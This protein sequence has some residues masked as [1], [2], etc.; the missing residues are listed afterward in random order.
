MLP[1]TEEK[2]SGE[3]EDHVSQSMELQLHH[4]LLTVRLMEGFNVVLYQTERKF[5]HTLDNFLL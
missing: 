3:C 4:S 5:R 1:Q 2:G